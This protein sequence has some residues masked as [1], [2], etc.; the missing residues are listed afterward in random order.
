MNGL[1]SKVGIPILAVTS[2][3]T[4]VIGTLGQSTRGCR[5]LCL[6]KVRCTMRHLSYEKHGLLWCSNCEVAINTHRCECCNQQ[7]RMKA[8]RRLRLASP[9]TKFVMDDDDDDSNG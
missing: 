2:N 5:G 3:M 7:G 4:L 9:N 8:R 6:T 1:V